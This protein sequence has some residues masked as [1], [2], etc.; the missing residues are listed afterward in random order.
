MAFK[1]LKFIKWLQNPF[2]TLPS[3]NHMEEILHT[4]SQMVLFILRI[5]DSAFPSSFNWINC[6]AEKSWELS[7]AVL[8]CCCS[9]LLH[10]LEDGWI[11]WDITAY[12]ILLKIIAASLQK[13]KK[14]TPVF[15]KMLMNW[16]GKPLC[17][18]VEKVTDMQ[19]AVF[20]AKELRYSCFLGLF[21][22]QSTLFLDI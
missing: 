8:F 20:W 1:Q 13:K 21:V 18:C 15:H 17:S 10:M 2:C 22:S 3:C 5:S 7:P 19:T 14:K 6:Y 4:V 12:V 16:L 11:S 9:L